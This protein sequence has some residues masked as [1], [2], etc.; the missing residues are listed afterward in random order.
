M[1]TRDYILE[2][3]LEPYI[4][5]TSAEIEAAASLAVRDAEVAEMLRLCREMAG[6]SEAALFGEPRTS[7]AA[8]LVSLRERITPAVSTEPRPVFGTR[9]M[10]AAVSVACL[11]LFIL[12]FGG[13]KFSTKLSLADDQSIS[14]VASVLESPVVFSLDSLAETSAD[15]DSLASY[16]DV[17]G[18]AENWDFADDSN[19][20]VT[21]ALLELDSQ[22]LAEVL[23]ELENTNFF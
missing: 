21:D 2:R 22:T 13:N 3:L 11:V 8:F 15:P 18:M 4:T 17:S 20:P 6:L 23:N 14:A 1:F 12:I 9:R 19:T 7:D 16:L 5:L 10:L